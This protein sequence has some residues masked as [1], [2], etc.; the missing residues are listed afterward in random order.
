MKMLV[1]IPL[2]VVAAVGAVAC[3]LAALGAAV[4]PIEPA[5]ACAAAALGAVIGAAPMLR[6]AGRSL[7]ATVQFALAGTVMHMMSTGILAAVLVIGGAVSI[8]GNFVY[9]LIGAYW[10]SLA[11]LVWQLRRIIISR[12]ERAKAQG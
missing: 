4:K 11:A 7:V 1:V 5:L 3:L 9:W 12:A 6:T 10:V 8:R 2:E